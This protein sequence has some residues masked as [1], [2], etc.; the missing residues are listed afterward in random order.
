MSSAIR[1]WNRM[2]PFN[3]LGALGAA[4]DIKKASESMK[5]EDFEKFLPG[6]LS[7]LVASGAMTADQIKQI[8]CA[9]SPILASRPA[10]QAAFAAYAPP[11]ACANNP[12]MPPLKKP[13]N[14]LLWI[15]VGAG[16]LALVGGAIWWMRRNR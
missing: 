10:V 8:Y 12:A 2:S 1:M 11:G 16:A 14:W 7:L 9:L 13:I 5:P 15:G 3:G 6:A 4:D